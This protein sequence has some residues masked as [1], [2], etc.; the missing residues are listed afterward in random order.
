MYLNGSVRYV[1]VFILL[2]LFAKFEKENYH[3]FKLDRG[4][5]YRV[6]ASCRGQE[7]ASYGILCISFEIG[8]IPYN[9][10]LFCHLPGRAGEILM[11]VI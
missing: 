10:S 6:M 8:L 9:C 3:V 5:L 7:N 2:F 11:G 4:K 1:V